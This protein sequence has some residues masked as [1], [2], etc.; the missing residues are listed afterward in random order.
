MEN[1]IICDTATVITQYQT[2]ECL[3]NGYFLAEVPNVALGNYY[4]G[5]AATYAHF[6]MT[7]GGVS[8]SDLLKLKYVAHGK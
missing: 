1:Q 2:C 7:Y 3:S 8:F 5:K 6:L 4:Q